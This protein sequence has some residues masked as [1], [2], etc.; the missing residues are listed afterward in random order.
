MSTD[1]SCHNNKGSSLFIID[2]GFAQNGF[3]VQ[4]EPLGLPWAASQG[5]K[6]AS[7]F[8][9]T[10]FPNL[11]VDL[12]NR[13]PNKRCLKTPGVSLSPLFQLVGLQCSLVCPHH[14]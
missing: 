12:N 3:P 11:L 2:Q 13:I 8:I 4:W 6:I 14:F 1:H 7:A 9:S 10:G 5:S